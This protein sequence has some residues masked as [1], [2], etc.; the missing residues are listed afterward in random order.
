MSNIINN[1]TNNTS[2]INYNSYFL[3]TYKSFAE[4]KDCLLCYQ[5]QLLQAFNMTYYDDYILQK[6][7]EKATL[8][9]KNNGEIK[10]I[11]SILSK[12]NAYL[13]ILKAL[14]NDT[15]SI[16]FFQLLFSYEYFDIFH[17]C[18]S[19]Y[20]NYLLKQDSLPNDKKFFKELED[21]ILNE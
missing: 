9:L 19:A 3:C 11:V 10:K 7:I 6:N 12:K 1:I 13:E 4:E 15:E 5:I 2:N 8:F 20:L 17:K 16:F 18:L 21:H 14:N